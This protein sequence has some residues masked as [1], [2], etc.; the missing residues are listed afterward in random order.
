MWVEAGSLRCVE[1]DY[2]GD[3]LAA[4]VVV[5]IKDNQNTSPN[6]DHDNTSNDDD[7]REEDSPSMKRMKLE[8]DV[9]LAIFGDIFK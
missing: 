7:L 1:V 9:D 3:L 4:K 5:A 2:V 8:A 6:K